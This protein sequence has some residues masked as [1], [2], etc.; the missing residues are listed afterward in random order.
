MC[1]MTHWYV[2]HDSLT[3]SASPWTSDVTDYAMVSMTFL[4]V[5]H[6]SFMCVTCLIHMCDMTHSYVWHD[7]FTCV[8]WLIHMS[9]ITHPRSLP[10][11]GL[12]LSWNTHGIYDLFTRVTWL[13]HTCDMTHPYMWHDSFICDVT[14]PHDWHDSIKFDVNRWYV[15][16]CRSQYCSF[17]WLIHAWHES[18]ISDTIHSNS[19]WIINMSHAAGLNIVVSHVPS[20]TSTWALLG[21]LGHTDLHVWHD[22]TMYDMTHYCVTWFIQI[23]RESLICDVLQ[24]SVLWFYTFHL[25]RLPKA[26]WAGWDTLTYTCNM[27]RS[28]VTWLIYFRHDPFEFDVNHWYVTCCRFRYCGITR[29]ISDGCTRIAGRAGTLMKSQGLALRNICAC[30]F[31]LQLQVENTATRCNTLHCNTLQNTATCLALFRTREHQGRFAQVHSR[32]S[33]K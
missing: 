17:T 21:V 2:W 15:T 5:W 16:C 9:D 30:T 4:Y 18:F 7:S 33:L 28:C 22:W 19:T 25:K 29:A 14:H 10:V 13:I 1:D 12:V 23:R 26:G 6:D 32:G 11:L 20:Q 8:T 31:P 24:F 3:L 27:T